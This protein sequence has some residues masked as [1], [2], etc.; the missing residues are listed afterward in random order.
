V[1]GKPLISFIFLGVSFMRC[2][3]LDVNI[4]LA[5]DN[6]CF[7]RHWVHINNSRQLLLCDRHCSSKHLSNSLPHI[8]PS[9]W[10]ILQSKKLGPRGQQNQAN[11]MVAVEGWLEFWKSTFLPLC[12]KPPTLEDVFFSPSLSPSCS[13]PASLTPTHTHTQ[14]TYPLTLLPTPY[15]LP[16]PSLLSH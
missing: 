15:L 14:P 13:S 7:L 16:H 11:K 4:S 8:L 12:H 9:T 5:R 1:S 10:T 6:K 3:K 2:I